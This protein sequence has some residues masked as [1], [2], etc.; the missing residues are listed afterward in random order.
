MTKRIRHTL[1][2]PGDFFVE[3]GPCTA[4]DAPCYHAP[5]LIDYDED[6]HC[7]FKKQ[8]ET[9]AEIEHAIK[10]VQVS[11][12][13]GLVYAGNDPEIL[14]ILEKSCCEIYD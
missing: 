8:P 9:E 12:C 3:D 10:A 4:C 5:E 11:C 6:F 7:Y 14:R 1:N 2:V 13:E